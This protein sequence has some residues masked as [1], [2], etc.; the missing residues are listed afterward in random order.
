MFLNKS[1]RFKFAS[2]SSLSNLNHIYILP[3]AQLPTPKKLLLSPITPLHP[4]PPHRKS[5]RTFQHPKMADTTGSESIASGTISASAPG[6]NYEPRQTHPS[7]DYTPDP[8]K[9]LPLSPARQALLDDIIALYNCEPTVRRVERYTPDC[10]YD[11]QFVYANDRYKMAGQWFA[12]P[13]LFNE[14]RN[15]GYQVVV[16]EPGLIQFRNEQVTLFSFS[17][18]NPQFPPPNKQKPVF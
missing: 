1:V 16:N 3:S 2:Q 14:S 10:V 9:S 15:I 12:L 6:E 13:K 8:S 18:A 17:P 11:D 5:F 4:S 7:E